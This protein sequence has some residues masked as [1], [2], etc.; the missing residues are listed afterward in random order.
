MLAFEH[1]EVLLAIDFRIVVLRVDSRIVAPKQAIDVL[2]VLGRKS[3]E[4]QLLDL[5]ELGYHLLV[6]LESCGTIGTLVLEVIVAQAAEGEEAS[7]VE[8]RIDQ[9]A[10][11]ATELLGI[12]ASHRGA[13]DEVGLLLCRIV[14]QKLQGFERRYRNIGRHH[15]DVLFVEHVAHQS[16]CACRTSRTETVDIKYLFHLF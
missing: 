9:N 12:H 4:Q 6:N 16:G 7:H 5:L 1:H 11:V 13:D 2:L 8:R 3:L 14:L 15:A 10:L